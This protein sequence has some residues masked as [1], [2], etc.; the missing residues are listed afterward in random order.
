[1][2][3]SERVW[4]LDNN[5]RGHVCRSNATVGETLIYTAGVVATVMSFSL[6]GRQVGSVPSS[7][8]NNLALRFHL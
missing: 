6:S 1:M 3:S 8:R 7:T 2:L 4:W 5:C